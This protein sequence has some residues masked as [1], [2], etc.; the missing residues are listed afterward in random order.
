MEVV[1]SKMNKKRPCDKCTK[2]LANRHSLSRHRK[3]CKGQN[4]LT[5]IKNK[6]FG[7]TI[8]HDD[9][10]QIEDDTSLL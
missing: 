6:D 5:V 1:T 8:A 9:S 4:H 10:M 3:T 7:N 2:L